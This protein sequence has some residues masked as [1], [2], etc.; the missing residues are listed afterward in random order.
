MKDGKIAV[1]SYNG[2]NFPEWEMAMIALLREKGLWRVVEEDPLRLKQGEDPK[3][4]EYQ[5]RRDQWLDKN[6]QALGRITGRVELKFAEEFREMKTASEVWTAIKNQVMADKS[7]NMILWRTEI[8]SIHMG[9]D[10]D[11]NAYFGN[12]ERLQRL[13]RD[14]EAPVGDGELVLRISKGLPKSWDGFLASVRGSQR[15]KEA[16]NPYA[17]VKED[18]LCEWRTRQCFRPTEVKE[19]RAAML[20]E[21]E[22]GPTIGQSTTGGKFSGTCYNCNK[23]GHRS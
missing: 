16:K 12:A 15:F 5:A 8:E 20:V 13:L 10:G 14:T 2:L 6:E 1:V 17:M 7:G 21:K 9:E 19:P 23:P 4:K 22:R 11:M 18:V 3:S